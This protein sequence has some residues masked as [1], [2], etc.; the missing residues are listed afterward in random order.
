MTRGIKFLVNSFCT[1]I[2][3]A[4][5]LIAVHDVAFETPK[6]KK[7]RTENAVMA[8]HH[9]V[10]ERQLDDVE[11]T[12]AQLLQIDQTLHKKLFDTAPGSSASTTM[13][14]ERLLLASAGDF[15]TLISDIE[16]RVNRLVS[17]SSRTN[18]SFGASLH[19]SRAEIIALQSIPTIQPVDNTQIDLLVSGFGER[20]NPYHKGMYNHPGVDFAAP[21]G[22]AVFATA[23]GKVITVKKT[24]LQ[25]GYGNYVEIDHGNGYVTRYAHLDG[26]D[27]RRGQQVYK[28]KVIGSSGNSGGS[29][30]P[31][32]HYEVIRNGVAVD[33]VNY[34]LEGLTSSQ[35]SAILSH[36]S[37]QNQSLD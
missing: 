33:P 20:I 23:P 5:A 32:L 12:L 18:T 19:I 27:V 1:A 26:I 21:R 17:S 25:A 6:T 2:L 9:P 7:M 36:A 28:G 3:L 29:V 37:A 30:A 15:R 8:N 16:N 14:K 22:S 31:H 11:H 35:Y 34:L 10:L 4:T 24:T 13:D